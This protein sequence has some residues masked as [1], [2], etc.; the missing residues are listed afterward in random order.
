[1]ILFNNIRLTNK[2]RIKD[3]KNNEM[4]QI[5]RV[6]AVTFL[7]ATFI[8]LMFLWW[9]ILLFR[10]NEN[11]SQA[12]IRAIKLE[13]KSEGRTLTEEELKQTPQYLEQKKFNEKTK[14]MILGEG[15]VLFIGLLWAIWV[16]YRSFQKEA[17][18]SSQRRN[19]LLSITH[20]LKSPIASIQL[21]LQTFQKRKLEEQQAQKLLVSANNEA[22]RLNELVNNLL[23]S[24]KLETAYEPVFENISLNPFFEDILAKMQVRFP[25][26]TLL[27]TENDLP[28]L[29]GDRQGLQSVFMNLIENAVKYSPVEPTIKLQY[30]FEKDTFIFNIADNGIGITNGEKKKIFERFYRIGSEE[31]R[32][33]KGTGLGLYI[34]NQI[35]KAHNGTIQVL[36][37]APKGTLFKIILPELT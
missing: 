35:V 7:A 24:A 17:D 28:I 31:T 6:R 37:N 11:T 36:D 12:W 33:T 25:K 20:E 13:M 9:T 15:S 14:R 32:T 27:L 5:N 18:L 23:L 1:V 4:N 8:V 30:S 2:G 29:R 10:L 34:V 26:A 3:F 22:D 21:I 16:L 19:F